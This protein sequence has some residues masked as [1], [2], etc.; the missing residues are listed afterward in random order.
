V[1]GRERVVALGVVGVLGG[2]LVVALPVMIG[3]LLVM[4]GGFLV[5]LG[6]LGVM[7]RGWV[8]CHHCASCLLD[9]AGGTSASV[10]RAWRLSRAAQT[11]GLTSVDV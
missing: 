5:V 7:F 4:L 6:C 9:L 10:R 2:L 1:V 8:L 3:S 11:I